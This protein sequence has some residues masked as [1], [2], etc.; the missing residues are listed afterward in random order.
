MKRDKLIMVIIFAFV[1]IMTACGKR[2]DS[3]VGDN[4]K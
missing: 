2:N 1:L 4:M 3:K